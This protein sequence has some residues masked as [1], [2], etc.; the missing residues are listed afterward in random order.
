[1][2]GMVEADLVLHLIRMS[3]IETQR[4]NY[5]GLKYLSTSSVGASYAQ[6]E[7]VKRNL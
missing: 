6:I 5:L 1:M 3:I 2:L 7:S 4:E